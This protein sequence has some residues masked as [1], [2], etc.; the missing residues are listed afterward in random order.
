[1]PTQR[2]LVRG[3]V[4]GVGFRAFVQRVAE[5][6]GLTGEVWNRRDGMVELIAQ[7]ADEAFLH[8][9]AHRLRHQGPG[10][11]EG[12]NIYPE[13]EKVRSGFHVGYTR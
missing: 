1:M 11:V 13:V 6:L 4:Q 9:L 5:E 10:Y 8:D 7:H 3:R 2:I 12:I